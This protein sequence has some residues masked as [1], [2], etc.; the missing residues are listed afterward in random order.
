[1]ATFSVKST[2]IWESTKEEIIESN[3]IG[4]LRPSFDKTP[5]IIGTPNVFRTL[6]GIGGI[7]TMPVVVTVNNKNKIFSNN[8]QITAIVNVE[9]TA[10][11]PNTITLSVIRGFCCKD[12]RPT[13]IE[14]PART[15]VSGPIKGQLT[16]GG[17]FTGTTPN[18]VFY[19]ILQATE[20][21][22]TFA[23]NGISISFKA[24]ALVN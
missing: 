3:T 14:L 18:T 17:I 12:V 9:N 16:G 21:A 24:E 13:S 10:F 6:K 15:V 1:M 22:N 7:Q 23:E 11:N 8:V 20:G 5:I 19:L 4:Q 2:L